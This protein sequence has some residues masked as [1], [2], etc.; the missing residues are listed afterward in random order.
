LD[1][2]TSRLGVIPVVCSEDTADTNGV[3]TTQPSPH[4]SQTP[5]EDSAAAQVRLSDLWDEDQVVIS[6]G[7]LRVLLGDSLTLLERIPSDNMDSVVCDP[8]YAIRSRQDVRS[9][10]VRAPRDTRDSCAGCGTA[11]SEEGLTVCA[12]CLRGLEVESFADAAML[13]QQ[14]TN[15]NEQATHS[16]GY[17]DNDPAAFQRWC[18][19]WVAQC[20]RILKPG[21]HMVAFGG[22][23]T[24]HR[25][26]VAAEDAG[27]EIRDSLAWLYGTGFPK[28]V[29]VARAMA[30]TRPGEDDLANRAADPD[31]SSPWAGW[32]TAMKPAHEPIILARKP[33]SGTVATNV[34]RYGTG[35]LDIQGCR[36]PP[37]GGPGDT[38][39]WPTNVFL[40]D[41]QAAV[42]DQSPTAARPS[43]FFWVAKPS[44]AEKSLVEG[45]S[46]PTVKPLALIREL[47]RLVTP[48]GGVVLDPFAGSGTTVEACMLEHRGCVAIERDR[49]YL[50]LIRARIDRHTH[51]AVSGASN[52]E[53]ANNQPKDGDQLSL[54]ASESGSH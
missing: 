3:T 8:P 43:R 45:L 20:L 28:S 44:R 38:S 1:G 12:E 32:G 37:G 46:H 54:F 14:S 22:T 15:W 35:A 51:T 31:G 24:W 41:E 30:R 18:T 42:L 6:R 4:T 53:P 11:D 34:R 9:R 52:D 25:L 2:Y 33:L 50:P 48:P 10:L 27:F 26:A 29:D 23:R 13:G 47:V 5:S 49:E 7:N 19:L 40:S 36:I 16:R 21:G 17:A 39:R